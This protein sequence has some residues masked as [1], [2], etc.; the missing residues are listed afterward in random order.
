MTC[1]E[2]ARRFATNVTSHSVW[3][4]SKKLGIKPAK[5]YPTPEHKKATGEG[6]KAVLSPFHYEYVKEWLNKK[7]RRE[8]A[9]NLGVS[10]NIIARLVEE[11]NLTVDQQQ[12]KIFHKEGSR[13]H[14]QK[15]TE[16]SN[17][18][19]DDPK[20]RE[21]MSQK[22]REKNKRLWASEQYRL[23]VRN[24]IRKTYDN[25]DLRDRLSLIGK[26]RYNTDP[27]V[28][29]ILSSDRQFK[30]SKLNDT[31][32]IKLESFGIKFEREFALANYKF[33][34]KIGDILLEVNGSY[35]HSLPN[36]I[37][38]DKAKSEIVNRYFPQFKLRVIWEGELKSIRANDRLLELLDIKEVKPE[39]INLSDVSV[40]DQYDVKEVD[41]F[42]MSF[43]YLGT[44]KR[45][46]HVFRVTLFGETIAVATFGPPVRPNTAP[47]RVIELIRLCR[48]PRFHN[49]NLMSFFLSKCER[50]L[51]VLDRYDNIVS[52][53]DLRLHQG[54]I[55]KACNWEDCGETEPDYNYM[56]AANIPI[57]KKTLYNRAVAEGLLERQYAEKYGYTKVNIGSKRK[58][59][60][61]LRRCISI[62]STCRHGP[63]PI[64]ALPLDDSADGCA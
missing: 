37:K 55:Y 40:T 43:H 45:K 36:G 63:C 35:W 31:V 49:K 18:R 46:R 26:E 56:S 33:D 29:E 10:M 42:L 30:N 41:K 20:F 22:I 14:I 48:H 19:W 32:A 38:N 51:A 12:V 5:Y 53:A 11:L 23:K 3:L 7:S 9:R 1:A 64:R 47:G 61:Q 57:H 34:F 59:I 52:F 17:R 25:T 21:M 54:T 39:E 44:T 58:F 6:A 27:R 13:A 62:I 50:K 2:F 28:R 8:I 4:W 16:A 15:A 24:G 60:K